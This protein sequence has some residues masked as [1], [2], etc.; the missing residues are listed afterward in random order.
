ML[1]R[2]IQCGFTLIEAMVAVALVSFVLLV[3][4]P[5]FANMVSNLRVRS[6]SDSVLSGIQAARIEALKRN[7]GITFELDPVSG[8][9]GGWRVYPTGNSADVLHSKGS[10][11]GGEVLVGLDTGDTQILFGRLGQRTYPDAATPVLAVDISNPNFDLCEAAGGS[12]RCLR[13]AVSIG[14]ESRLCDPKRP[15]GDPQAC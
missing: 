10:S 15:T 14:G 5:A 6:V 12:V 9:G 7:I 4:L 2:H 13:V 8:V 11:E 3:G 1:N